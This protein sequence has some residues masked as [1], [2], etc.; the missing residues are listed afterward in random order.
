MQSLFS[1]NTC[2]AVDDI[3]W[4]FQSHPVIRSWN[5]N[6]HVHF[7][8]KSL[9]DYLNQLKQHAK[10][11]KGNGAKPLVSLHVSQLK[12]QSSKKQIS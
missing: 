7:L 8:S 5:H 3:I 1:S 4:T 9:E 11:L 6:S 2:I 10:T 12:W